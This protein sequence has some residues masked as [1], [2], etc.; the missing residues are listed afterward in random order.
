[1]P[2]SAALHSRAAHPYSPAILARG[3]AGPAAQPCADEDAEPDFEARRSL[4]TRAG[5]APL[6]R[7]AA[8]LVAISHNNSYEGRDP[9]V[10]PD[11]LASGFVADLLGLGLTSLA[12]TLVELKARGLIVAAPQSGLRL[13]DLAG[14]ESLAE[15]A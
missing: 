10:I 15:T 6:Q 13:M 2:T 9:R 4:A 3:P 14:L 1:M 12:A 7:V 11:S 5:R 8:F